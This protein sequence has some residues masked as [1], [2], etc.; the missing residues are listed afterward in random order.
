M[1]MYE[2]P[3]LLRRSDLDASLNIALKFK[4]NGDLM[5]DIVFFKSHILTESQNKQTKKK[6]RN[7]AMFPPLSCAT[8]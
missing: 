2:F 6:Q 1:M 5:R 8:R 3:P 4:R 7:E